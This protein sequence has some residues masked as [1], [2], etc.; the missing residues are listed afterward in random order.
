MAAISIVDKNDVTVT[1]CNHSL[2]NMRGG[3]T[4]RRRL[5]STFYCMDVLE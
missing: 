2:N 1:A 4:L 5:L 3:S